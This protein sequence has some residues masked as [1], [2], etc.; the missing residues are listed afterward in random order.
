MFY[1]FRPTIEFLSVQIRG[2]GSG[3]T[4]HGPTPGSYHSWQTIEDSWKRFIDT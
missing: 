2:L 3:R 1:F 4:T